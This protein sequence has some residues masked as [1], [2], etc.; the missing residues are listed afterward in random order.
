M[1]E[2]GLKGEEVKKV[3]G[4]SSVFLQKLEYFSDI[5]IFQ[6]VFGY[7]TEYTCIKLCP[8]A[9]TLEMTQQD[10]NRSR[11]NDMM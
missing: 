6:D 1:F 11:I 9:K 3:F 4:F 2:R 8:K 10:R 5:L 7:A